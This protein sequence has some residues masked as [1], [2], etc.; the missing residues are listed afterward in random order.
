MLGLPLSSLAINISVPAAPKENY[1]LISNAFGSYN[2]TTTP[3]VGYLTAT[4][5][6]PSTFAS[7]VGIGTS[8]PSNTLEVNGTT[9]LLGNVTTTGLLQANGTTTLTRLGVGTS[10]PAALLEVDSTAYLGSDASMDA[11]ATEATLGFYSNDGSTGAQ[12]VAASI[13]MLTG[14]TTWGASVFFHDAHLAFDTIY[15]GTLLERMRILNNGNIGIGTTTP[16]SILSVQGVTGT[17]PFT[18]S[19]STGNVMLTVLQNGNVGIGTAIPTATLD[20]VGATPT[21]AS[22]FRINQSATL[23]SNTYSVFNL[24]NSDTTTGN[25]ALFS[26]SDNAGTQSSAGIGAMFTDRTNHYA[27]LYF[28]T[29]SS[30]SYNQRLYIQANGNVGIGT[31]TPNTKLNIYGGGLGINPGATAQP[32]CATSTRGMIWNT[33]GAAGVADTFQ[34]CQKNAADVMGWVTK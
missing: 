18:V 25:H 21:F 29:K 14:G 26:F 5:T 7:K 24:A 34:V 11:N 2:P 28:Y 13:R 6:T 30:D 23:W 33:F 9:F 27:D 17:N 22:R 12:K 19:S 1:L 31:T 8:S 16:L 4:S 3:I 10:Y 20:V 15:Q 32:T